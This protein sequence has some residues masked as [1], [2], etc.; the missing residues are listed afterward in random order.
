MLNVDKD[1][2][3]ELH[4][5]TF[6]NKISN[7]NVLEPYIDEIKQKASRNRSSMLPSLPYS[8]FKRFFED[9]DRESFQQLYFNRRSRLTTSALMVFL[10]KKGEDLIELEDI[11]WEICNEYSWALPAHMEIDKPLTIDLFAAETSFALAEILY[12]LQDRLSKDIIMRVLEE[13]EKRVLI[14]YCT[15]GKIYPWEDMENNWSAVCASSIGATAIYVERDPIRR[16][17]IMDRVDTTLKAFLR[18]FKPDG[19]CLEGLS[20]WTY[21]VSF[22]IS[23]ADLLYR[24][25]K[26]RSLLCREKFEKIITFQ[27]K[28]YLGNS[29]TI[30]FSDSSTDEKYRLG[31]AS[32]LSHNF[33]NFETPPLSKHA[34]YN[35]DPCYRWCNLLRD[36]VWTTKYRTKKSETE[37]TDFSFFLKDSQ[38]FIHKSKKSFSLAFK[39]GTNSEPHNHND[40]GSFVL[41]KNDELFL[42]DLGSGL[43]TRD[44]FSEGRYAIFCN[45]SLSH[46]VPIINGK[47]Q[48]AGNQFKACNTKYDKSNNIIEMDISLAY[49]IEELSSLTRKISISHK[50][51]LLEDKIDFTGEELHITERFITKIQPIIKRDKVILYGIDNFLTIQLSDLMI[52]PDIKEFKHINH[53]GSTE[54]VYAIDYDLLLYRGKHQLVWIFS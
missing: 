22:Y 11:I 46:S 26:D 44:Y 48:L 13:I 51:I 9:G 37:M 40:I 23:Y 30:S 10:F 15:P 8:L 47:E 16:K 7:S 54:T 27:Q 1:F 2:F 35:D 20:Y 33:K 38:W 31:L 49:N 14:P 43:Y 18:S 50:T 17:Q 12:I 28:C 53:K 45:S 4:S 29:Y 34:Q 41:L 52:S 5:E 39:G 24:Y 36:L 6:L 25:N 42:T 3:P 32:F 21:G 19:V